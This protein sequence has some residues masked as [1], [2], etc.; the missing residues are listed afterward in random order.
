ML[1]LSDITDEMPENLGD[2]ERAMNGAAEALRGSRTA[3]ALQEMG[4]ALE[5][6]QQ[7]QDDMQNRA[8]QGM[9]GGPG[10]KPAM[11]FGLAPK[12]RRMPGTDQGRDPLG[13]EMEEAG[14]GSGSDVKIPAQSD[15][16]RARDILN[17]LRKRSSEF[18]RP[19]DELDYIDRLLDRF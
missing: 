11:R 3:K 2:A 4:E 19:Q 13:R 12:Q 16:Q 18:E 10:G 5:A 7:M 8:N 15:L 6:L 14:R 9:A 17:E 1:D